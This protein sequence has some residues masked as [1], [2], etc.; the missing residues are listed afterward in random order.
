MRIQQ[1]TLVLIFA[2]VFLQKSDSSWRYMFLGDLD[3][4][5][6]G[7]YSSLQSK[8][9]LQEI[10]LLPQS[11]TNEQF[12][13]AMK[14]VERID[15]LP[16][17]L[18]EKLR[19]KRV[20]LQLFEGNLTDLPSVRHLK[21][22]SPRGYKNA[23]ITW[24]D[25]PGAGGSNIVLAKI[26]Y[27]DKGNGHGSVNLELHELAHSIDK[28]IFDYLRYDDDFLE[29]WQEERLK[30]FDSGHYLSEYPE[31]YFAECFAYFYKDETTNEILHEKAP[32]TYLFIEQLQ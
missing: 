28:I 17:S 11:H 8:E 14:M 3:Q 20:Y 13:Q 7:H 1:L 21:G 5:F 24:D 27:S 12:S 16:P 26:G 32:K 18:L 6:S 23:A 9:I 10:I 19:E 22:I 25:V 15:H 30:I 4:N 29:I 2:L 31:E